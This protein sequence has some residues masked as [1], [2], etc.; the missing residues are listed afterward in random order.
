MPITP[1]PDNIIVV[2]KYLS[3]V[4]D[5]E[6]LKSQIFTALRKEGSWNLDSLHK[7]FVEFYYDFETV[8]KFKSKKPMDFLNKV[9]KCAKGSSPY[10]IHVLILRTTETGSEIEVKCIPLLYLFMTQ[11]VGYLEAYPVSIVGIKSCAFESIGLIRRLFVGA[12]ECEELDPPH[13]VKPVEERLYEILFNTKDNRELTQ[14]IVS[15]LENAKKEVCVSGWIGTYIIPTLKK[16][17][18]NHVKMRFITK[19]PSEPTIGYRDKVEALNELKTFLKKDDLG[20][21]RTGHFRLVIVDDHCIFVGAMDMDSESLAEREEGAIYSTD[22]YLVA[23]A[24]IRF[25]EFFQKCEH[26]K[27]W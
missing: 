12:L 15:E 25:N 19:T 8:M 21:L 3:P 18:K 22:L 27:G 11:I 7:R 26:P 6:L 23:K 16:L 5:L 1:D 2:A 17:N 14:K 9:V 4:K 13:P 24:K 20:L 10:K